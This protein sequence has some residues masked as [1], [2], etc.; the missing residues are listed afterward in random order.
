MA[1]AVYAPSEASPP[2]LQLVLNVRFSAGRTASRRGDM[3]LGGPSPTVEDQMRTHHCMPTRRGR[4]AS[5]ANGQ[6]R[7]QQAPARTSH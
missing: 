2:L 1:G 4:S 7:H 5:H 6:V 3:A